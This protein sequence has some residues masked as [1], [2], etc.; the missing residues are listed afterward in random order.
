MLNSRIIRHCQITGLGLPEETRAFA[1][2]EDATGG[3]KSLKKYWTACV[4]VVLGLYIVY[5]A[6]Q[7]WQKLLI[8][9][10][11]GPWQCNL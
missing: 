6:L 9:M 10:N 7:S 4:S 3:V 1:S 11:D 8:C 5:R 2:C